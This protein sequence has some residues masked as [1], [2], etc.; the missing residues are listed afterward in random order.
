[1]QEHKFEIMNESRHEPIIGIDSAYDEEHG[2]TT[3]D[4]KILEL[5]YEVISY[6]TI[7]RSGLSDSYCDM[8]RCAAENNRSETNYLNLETYSNYVLDVTFAYAGRKHYD[9]LREIINNFLN[10]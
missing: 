9:T 5:A 6:I 8:I 3:L 2:I 1:M 7:N 4:P 10:R